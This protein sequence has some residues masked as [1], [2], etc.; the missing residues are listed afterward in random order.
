MRLHT[1]K[2]V[3]REEL[4]VATHQYAQDVE[5]AMQV[6]VPRRTGAL[7]G[8]L[9]TEVEYERTAVPYPKIKLSRVIRDPGSEYG[10]FVDDGTGIYHIPDPHPPWVQANL[11][12]PMPWSRHQ[13]VLLP[14]NPAV[15]WGQPAAD[16]TGKALRATAIERRRHFN[17]AGHRIARRLSN[18]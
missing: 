18:A 10:V 17:A 3:V 16:F 12:L 7:A 14:L 6:F 8:S 11:A 1:A 13:R 9:G 2:A 15:H 5:A 4:T